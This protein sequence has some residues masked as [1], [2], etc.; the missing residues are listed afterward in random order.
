MESL[1]VGKHV[2]PSKNAAIIGSVFGKCP[3]HYDAICALRR[4]AKKIDG[5]KSLTERKRRQFDYFT[6]RKKPSCVLRQNP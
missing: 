4:T 1:A 5:K 3:S 6:L 2:P